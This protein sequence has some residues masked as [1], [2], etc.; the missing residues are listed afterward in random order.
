MKWAFVCCAHKRAASPPMR[1]AKRL[2]T[3]EDLRLCRGSSSYKSP[4]T[5][6]GTPASQAPQE[7]QTSIF[8]FL[9]LFYYHQLPKLGVL[10]Y[11]FPQFRQK[12]QLLKNGSSSSQ[13]SLCSGTPALLRGGSFFA[14][15]E[16]GFFPFAAGICERS[17]RVEC[18]ERTTRTLLKKRKCGRGNIYNNYYGV[19]FLSTH[20]KWWSR[21]PSSQHF[22]L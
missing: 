3:I 9:Q 14:L 22:P 10:L 20:R 6:R 2:P 8:F 19:S 15:W 5:K 18:A 1:C 16:C 21:L 17:E 7:F 13:K 12:L 11:G 4:S